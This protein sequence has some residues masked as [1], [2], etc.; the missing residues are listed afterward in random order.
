MKKSEILTQAIEIAK[1]TSL[2]DLWEIACVRKRKAFKDSDFTPVAL[3]YHPIKKEFEIYLHIDILSA[4]K[5]IPDQL[6]LIAWVGSWEV[7]NSNL[8]DIIL[9]RIDLA[10]KYETDTDILE[11]KCALKLKEIKDRIEISWK[12]LNDICKLK[13]IKH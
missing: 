11:K 10:I 12:E 6:I 5:K 3:I 13:Q 8:I 7:K 1:K 2:S 4:H 9:Q